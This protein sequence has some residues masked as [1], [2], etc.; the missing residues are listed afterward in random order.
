MKLRILALLI[1]MAS[2]FNFQPMA[3]A[4]EIS[5][6][7]EEIEVVKN[8]KLNYNELNKRLQQVEKN[9][10]EG[11]L[12][13]TLISEYLDGLSRTINALN[14]YKASTEKELQFVEKKI[15]ALGAAPEDGE[16]EVREIAQ[17]R[18][19]FN[20]EAAALKAR[21]SEADILLTQIDELDLMIIQVRNQAL[22]SRLLEKQ[23]SLI[24][25]Q[26][27]YT[28]NKLLATMLFDIA[29][30][31]FDWYL[32]LNDE[33]KDSV[34]SNIL[35]VIL[36]VVLTLL[37][38]IY[39]RLFIMKYFGYKTN[40]DRIR[41]SRKVSAAIFVALAY[42]IIPASLIGAAL[43]WVYNAELL[44]GSFFFVALTNA[45]VCLFYIV[46][47]RALTR[48]T[49][50]PYNE[51]WRLVKISTEKA[52]KLTRVAYFFITVIGVCSF[53]ER[54]AFKTD[55]SMDVIYYI[56]AISSA[57]KGLSVIMIVKTMLW[58]DVQVTDDDDNIQPRELTD[59]EISDEEHLN[60][61]VKITF[62]VSLLCI[63]VFSLSLFGYQRLSSFIFD[64][65]IGSALVVGIFL[66]LRRAVSEILHRVLFLRF[67]ARTFKLR[68]RL[69]TKIDFW[70]TLI[71]DPIFIVAGALLILGMWGVSTDLML[72]SLKKILFGFK[73]GNV[74]VSVI[75]IVVGI[76]TFFVTLTVMKALRRHAVSN[77]LDKMDIDDGI[78]HSLISGFSFIS[79][80]IA[81]I[82][83]LLM[84]G[85]SFGN[86]ALIAGALSVGIG[87]GLQDVVNNFVSG[88]I[89]LFER[90]IKVGDW[91]KI[92]N[93]EGKVK[94]INIRSTE[95]ETFNRASVIVPNATLL[96]T[97]LTNLTHSNNWARYSV[98]VGVAYGS[99]VEK[100]KDI[101]MEC[102]TSHKRVLKKPE[103][104]VLFQN[105]GASSLDFE[106]RFYVSNIWDGFTAPSDIRYE[107]NR[108]FN[109]EGIE[110]PFAQLVVHQGSV[111]SEET[112]S[113]F[114]ASKKNKKGAKNAD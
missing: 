77:V 106:L 110:I 67:W 105:F 50:T 80:I 99:D 33:G 30:S 39:L 107:I 7:A 25:P 4:E 90:P 23:E 3:Y 92:N 31:P 98:T 16:K 38:S 34:K 20:A 78:K 74:E 104:Y 97:S 108:R 35:P 65:F 102:A 40:D 49:L 10:K 26:N 44:K 72:Q 28:A 45:L 113:Q 79:F 68:R 81:A 85:G 83:A 84:M 71:V 46:I 43:Y 100:V 1:F 18:T 94:Q 82:L 27:F 19:E 63:G 95:I 51:P 15:E 55:S 52:K 111:V 75:S 53:F 42:G 9:V 13:S 32:N 69:I 58:D 24:L 22:V 14:N 76:I 93:E 21:L 60:P 86:L 48:V 112:E 54:I 36:V 87:L 17:K 47:C 103:P 73:V 70:L 61:K 8:G 6:K 59:E 56:M 114:Y 2:Y 11:N 62:I 66:I 91:V 12:S 57:V 96:S 29:S 101:L 88:I 89:L 5:S 109:E 41:Y 37:V 64:R